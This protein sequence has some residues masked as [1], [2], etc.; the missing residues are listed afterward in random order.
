M[1]NRVVKDPLQ[2]VSGIGSALQKE[3]SLREIHQSAGRTR[4]VIPVVG[5]LVILTERFMFLA[6]SRVARDRHSPQR[7]TV[8]EPVRGEAVIRVAGRQRQVRHSGRKKR[9]PNCMPVQI[10]LLAKRD[11]I[12]KIGAR[13]CAEW[14]DHPHN[15][16]IQ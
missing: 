8:P 12:L 5:E 3:H 13:G 2:H 6:R 9:G 7:D 4:L 16:K 11:Q 15:L 14:L 1:Q 10:P